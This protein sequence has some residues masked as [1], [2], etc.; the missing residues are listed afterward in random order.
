VSDLTVTVSGTSTALESFESI[1]GQDLNGGGVTGVPTV[2]Q[3]DTSSFG[4]TSLTEIWYNYFLDNSS[5]SGPELKYGG[6]DV[7]AGQF[8]GWVPIGAVQTASGYDVAWEI[9]GAN[10]YIVWSTDSNGN[11]V[12]D[13]TVTVSGT[14]TALE[15]F[16]SI[17]GQDLNGDGVIGLYAAPGTTLQID[18]PMADL[19]GSA[20]IGAGATLELAVADSGSVTF[21]SS[22]GTLILDG[23]STFS[24]EIFNFT[25]NG[26]LS[27][28]DQIDL[29][30]INYN[31]VHDS[32]AN[33]VLTVTD[34]TDT[35]E[36]NFNGSYTL[37]NFKFASDGSGGT[38]VYDPPVP[39]S[40]TPASCSAYL[41]NGKQ[42][43]GTPSLA[44]G[45]QRANIALL[46]NYMASSFAVAS[47]N[48]GGPMAVAETSEL[49]RQ[50]MLSSPSACIQHA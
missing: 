20:T 27:G 50:W 43:D 30:G 4:A 19:S 34:G 42:T 32:Y 21:N 14:S 1:F 22:T 37:A 11:Y 8:G 41:A 15:S 26:S 38:I 2:I 13:L 45:A 44:D 23:P 12:S 9:P 48:Q 49:G 25:G 35:A 18:A 46:G 10:E 29:K 36:L 47:Y 5:G 40:N 7:A 3:T 33:G 17:F 16:E 28:S 39:T 6:A 31:S 24:G